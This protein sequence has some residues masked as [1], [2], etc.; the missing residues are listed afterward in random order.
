MRVRLLLFAR[1]R[2]LAGTAEL[3]LEL[4]PD[5][6]AAD[7]VDAL[8]ARSSDCSRIPAQ[9][10]VAINQDYAALTARLSPGDELALLPPVAGG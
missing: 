8:R 9:P 6:T 7:A 10:V 3:E 5:A 1:Y 2:E 4:P